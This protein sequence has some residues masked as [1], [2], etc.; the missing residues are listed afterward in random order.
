MGKINFTQ[1]PC[2][3]YHQT[4]FK[5]S[6]QSVLTFLNLSQ[7]QNSVIKQSHLQHQKSPTLSFPE[8][9]LHTMENFLK[10]LTLGLRL[11][12]TLG[13]QTSQ[14][15]HQAWHRK[16]LSVIRML[17]PA[18]PSTITRSTQGTWVPLTRSWTLLRYPSLPLPPLI[19]LSR[20]LSTAT[21]SCPPHLHLL[22]WIL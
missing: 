19:F 15:T 12:S 14:S 21:R 2:F 13:S 10:Y 17:V 1:K 20:N 4:F 18:H 8:E 7:I 11:I 5:S 16:K 6:T 22:S 3:H 9:K